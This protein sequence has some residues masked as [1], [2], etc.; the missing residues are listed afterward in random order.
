VKKTK[1]RKPHAPRVTGRGSAAGSAPIATIHDVARRSSVS[2]ATVSRVINA[3]GRV[4]EKTRR[5]VENAVRQL[6]FVPNVLAS[7]LVTKRSQCVGLIIPS[8]C[9]FFAPLVTEVEQVVYAAGSY[10]MIIKATTDHDDLLKS[11][12]FLK[13]QRCESIILHPYKSSDAQIA[14][15]MDHEPNLV[16][17]HRWISEH[18]SRCV[19]VDNR[20]GARAAT[21]HLI[22]M[23]HREI[24]VIT[25]PRT[26]AEST[27]RLDGFKQTMTAAGLT[28]DP[29]LVVEGDFEFTT[30]ETGAAQL[31]ASG[32]AFTGM[33][34]FNDHMAIGAMSYLQSVGVR[35]P[36]QLSIV[37]FD[38]S[39]ASSQTFPRLTTV[40]QPIADIG[41]VAAQRALALS[42][43]AELPNGHTLFQ[44]KLI[45]RDS[46]I[47][48]RPQNDTTDAHAFGLASSV[49]TAP[50]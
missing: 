40:Y 49:V 12:Q 41:R 46:V 29:R 18:A 28:V 30:G 32:R 4:R 26:D 44:P 1:T 14:A 15:L 13:Q 31:L 9:P 42:T 27:E 23:G 19:S 34:C 37:G 45:V 17:I 21:R 36:D 50:R 25:G 8:I 43:K 6:Q 39:V 10:L 24:A 48:L 7:S 2:V 47:P 5:R 16:L 20:A 35:L 38:D 22:D 11:V 3:P 33:F